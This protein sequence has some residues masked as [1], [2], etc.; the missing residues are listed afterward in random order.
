[1]LRRQ[2]Q[3]TLPQRFCPA[4][5]EANSCSGARRIARQCPASPGAH[6]AGARQRRRLPVSSSHGSG[7][8]GGDRAL[9]HL[10]PLS[11]AGINAAAEGCFPVT[12]TTNK[13]PPARSHCAGARQRREQRSAAGAGGW[14]HYAVPR[15]RS[16]AWQLPE[17]F[18]GSFFSPRLP[19]L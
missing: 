14:R 8:T 13:Q 17:G 18:F 3:A 7:R 4:R 16:R 19:H 2:G 5:P 10:P 11:L 1:M 15:R 6:L 9:L 12:T